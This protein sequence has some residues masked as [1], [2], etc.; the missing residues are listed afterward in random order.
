[1]EWVILMKDVAENAKKLYSTPVLSKYGDLANLTAAASPK[2]RL[3]DGGPNNTKS[4]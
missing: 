3:M 1:M 2:A 4:T